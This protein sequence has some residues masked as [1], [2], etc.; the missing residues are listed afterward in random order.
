M[1]VAITGSHGLI[2]SALAASLRADGHRVRP[3]V[4]TAPS[5][6]DELAMADLDLTGV[7]AVVHLAGEGIAERR[8]DDEQKRKILESRRDGTR[9]VAAAVARAGTPVLLSGPAVGCYG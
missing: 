4:R 8:W 3:V 2:G 6:P 9:V 5:G 7:D 1:D